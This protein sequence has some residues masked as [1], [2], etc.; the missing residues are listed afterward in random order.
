MAAFDLTGLAI[1]V[2]VGGMFVA[3]GLGIDSVLLNRH[4]KSVDNFAL[5]WWFFFDNL[6]VL[7]VPRIAVGLYIKGKN[8]VLGRGFTPIFFLRSF[9]LSLVLTALTV[10]GGRAL[11]LALVLRCNEL[12]GGGPQSFSFWQLI[13]MG[14]GWT[15]TQ[16]LLHLVPVNV[17]FD[18]ATIFI[19]VLLLSKALEKPDYFLIGLVLL[20]IL[21][22][23]LLF[24]NAIY[25]A[26]RYDTASIVTVDGY[27]SIVPAF[28]RAFTLGCASFHLLTSKL[29]FIST[30]LLPTLIYLAMIVA[31]FLLREGFKLFRVSTMYLLEKSVE[32]KKTIFAHLGTTIGMAIAVG[33]CILEIGKA[34]AP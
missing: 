6:R 27:W 3:L 31:L 23:F 7:D 15:G 16:S 26:D 25:I 19:T 4:I 12:M 11:G 22:C 30:I 32:D 18:L 24:Y 2:A 13:S 33:K 21:A 17:A 14:W 29:L 34:L 5:R 20:D 8:K 9:V 10:P 1:M 28:L